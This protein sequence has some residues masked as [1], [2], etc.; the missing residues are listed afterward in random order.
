[1]IDTS[2]N[3]AQNGPSARGN[4]SEKD[5]SWFEKMADAWGKVLDDQAQRVITKSDEIG[6]GS[7]NMGAITK[8]SAEVQRLTYLSNS[9][10]TTVTSVGSALDTMARKQ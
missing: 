3:G 9:A 4:L 7:D 5:A 6:D 2:V 8:L 1:M 10:H